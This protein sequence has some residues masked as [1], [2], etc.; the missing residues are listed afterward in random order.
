MKIVRPSLLEY[1]IA[2]A[3]NLSPL[4]NRYAAQAKA[5]GCI[6]GARIDDAY[7]GFLCISDD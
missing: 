7:E 4:S 1:Y 5:G 2:F 6:Y 3:G